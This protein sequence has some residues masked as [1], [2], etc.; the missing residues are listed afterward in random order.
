MYSDNVLGKIDSN[1]NN[2]HDILGMKE[3]MKKLT[4]ASWH[5]VAVNR[6]PGGK[7]FTQ[8]WEV[9]FSR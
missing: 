1:G 7:R 6:N 8:N 3:L 2:G 9:P 4:S 5:P